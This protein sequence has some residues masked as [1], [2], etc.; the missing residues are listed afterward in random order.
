MTGC[1]QS[2]DTTSKGAEYS[3][4]VASSLCSTY[5]LFAGWEVR[6]VK[7]CDRGLE[8][9]PEDNEEHKVTRGFYP[10]RG[11][12]TRTVFCLRKDWPVTGE[13]F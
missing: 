10:G 7:N 6:L 3:I 13:G 4:N 8:M 11:L 1:R 12:I 5:M 2:I 9:L